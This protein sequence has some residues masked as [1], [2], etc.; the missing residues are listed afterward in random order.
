MTQEPFRILVRTSF[1]KE[2]NTGAGAIL[3]VWKPEVGNGTHAYSG[4]YVQC[5]SK[6]YI[7]H[8][9]CGWQVY[10]ANYKEDS[11][12]PHFFVKAYSRSHG[13]LGENNFHFACDER[14][15]RERKRIFTH[16]YDDHHVSTPG[17]FKEIN[18]GILL[19]YLGKWADPNFIRR[20]EGIRRNPQLVES[21][22]W[23]IFR[24]HK[25][26]GYFWTGNFDNMT[27]QA[28]GVAFCGEVG[29]VG[30]QPD[31]L[32]QMGSGVAPRPGEDHRY[33]NVAYQRKIAFASVRGERKACRELTA[34]NVN[35]VKYSVSKISQQ[36]YD[37]KDDKKDGT[38]FDFGGPGDDPVIVS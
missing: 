26:I 35:A 34:D 11:L 17:H 30:E 25:A 22:V 14:D 24:D 36:P 9:T 3:S 18:V 28:D 15:L 2:K 16:G 10:P 38:R 31:E 12:K 23:W 27:K 13:V 21:K 33:K 8:I 29:W 6:D 19:D 4:A 1:E 5:Y 20:D 37:P 7:D 32:P